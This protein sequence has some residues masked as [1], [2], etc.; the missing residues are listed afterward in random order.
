MQE[1]YVYTVLD[2]GKP[3]ELS[4]VYVAFFTHHASF[5]FLFVLLETHSICICLCFIS[6]S[7]S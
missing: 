2:V 4:S 5:T 6:V 3:R 1:W 7:P